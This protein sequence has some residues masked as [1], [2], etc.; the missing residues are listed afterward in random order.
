MPTLNKKAI[1]DRGIKVT[2]YSKY[3]VSHMAD[4]IACLAANIE[5]AYRLAGV[6]DY[7]AKDCVD[8][9][10]KEVLREWMRDAPM[11]KNAE[12]HSD[13]TKD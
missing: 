9:V 3:D 6:T 4:V 8:M 10:A 11:A 2:R 12:I 7:T 13:T 1:S 5:D